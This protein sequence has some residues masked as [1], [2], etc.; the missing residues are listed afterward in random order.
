MELSE[1]REEIDR[2]DA[3]LTALFLRRMAVSGKIAAVKAAQGLPILNAARE[4]A[5]LD[6][7]SADA[8]EDLK[9]AVRALYTEILRLS[10]EYQASVTAQNA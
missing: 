3:E 5:V 1:L 2:I 8:P 6:R 4:A 7:V 9:D 10:R